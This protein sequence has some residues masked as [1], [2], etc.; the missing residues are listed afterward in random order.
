MKTRAAVA[1]WL[2]TLALCY[3]SFGQRK[4][5]SDEDTNTRSVQGV[6]TDAS[7]RRVAQAVVQLED[8]K[9]LQIRSFITEPDGS[10][11]FAGLS[12]NVE[13]ELRA[14]HD[15]ASSSKKTLDVFNTRKVATINLKLK[16]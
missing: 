7:G 1:A 4:K 14:N 6:V 12:A 10:Y 9:T 11:H 13:Y 3:S 8:T 16:R 5:N 2:I 15:G